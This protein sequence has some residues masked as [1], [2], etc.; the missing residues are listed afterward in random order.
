MSLHKAAR[1]SVGAERPQQEQANTDSS[2]VG[3]DARRR[4]R[5]ETRRAEL[6]RLGYQLLEL[7]D[8][9]YLI[10]KWDRSFHAECLRGVEAFLARVGGAA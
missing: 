8:G 4:K 3:D 6:A 1:P 9:T 10:C 2:I 7:S 5:F